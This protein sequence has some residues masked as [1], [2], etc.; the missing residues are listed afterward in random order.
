VSGIYCT[1]ASGGK[2]HLAIALGRAAVETGHSVLVTSA[3]ALLA[4]LA[5]AASEGQLADRHGLW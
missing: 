2:T 1:R 5:Q 3:R 4:A